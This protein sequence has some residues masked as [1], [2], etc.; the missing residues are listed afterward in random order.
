MGLSFAWTSAPLLVLAVTRSYQH[1]VRQELVFENAFKAAFAVRHFRLAVS[2]GQIHGSLWR[3]LKRSWLMCLPAMFA[4][5][6][7]AILAGPPNPIGQYRRGGE[8]ANLSASLS[9]SGLLNPN[10][11]EYPDSWPRRWAAL[12]CCWEVCG[13]DLDL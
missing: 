1:E 13:L 2:I 9:A 4:S 3:Q 11:F 8:A 10:G 6:W 5:R 12:P 7:R